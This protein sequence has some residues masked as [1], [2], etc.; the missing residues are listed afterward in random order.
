MILRR[1]VIRGT[2]AYIYAFESGTSKNIVNLW[3]MSE[4]EGKDGNASKE[5]RRVR[6]TSPMVAL[7]KRLTWLLRHHLDTS[8]LEVRNDGYVRVDELVGPLISIC[9]RF[10]HIVNP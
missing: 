4:Q 6:D 8:G 10:L 7:S 9:N 3:A 5:R 2:A 1:G